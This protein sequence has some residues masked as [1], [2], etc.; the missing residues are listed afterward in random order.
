M[1][2]LSITRCDILYSI[3]WIVSVI[4]MLLGDC[5]PVRSFFSFK[6]AHKDQ[7]AL[8][9]KLYVIYEKSKRI[10]AFLVI[11]FIA[12]VIYYTIYTTIIIKGWSMFLLL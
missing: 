2:S 1:P 3:S 6:Y 5:E 12:M 7:V 10:L 9:L 11:L 4:V 8:L